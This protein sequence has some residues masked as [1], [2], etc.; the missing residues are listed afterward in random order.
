MKDAMEYLSGGFASIVYDQH[1][2]MLYTIV[3]FKPL[4]HAYVKGLGF[5]LH[6][7]VDCLRE[8]IYDYTGCNR[9]GEFV[10]ES[11]YGHYLSPGI[12]EID[13]QS[14]FMRKVK[15]SPRFITPTWDSNFSN[16]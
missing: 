14:G 15:Y 16:K 6:S 7:D 8:L 11:W 5:F 2:D 10:W 1:K 13:L 3:D 12:R 4:A 9:D